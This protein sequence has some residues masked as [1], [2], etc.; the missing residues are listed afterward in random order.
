MFLLFHVKFLH[1]CAFS[2]HCLQK[3]SF[4][5]VII[6]Q[7]FNYIPCDYFT[8]KSFVGF[9]RSFSDVFFTFVILTLLSFSLLTFDENECNLTRLMIL[10]SFFSF[11]L[12]LFFA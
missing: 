11:A 9:V 4:P 5:Q 12:N 1:Y 7:Q 10:P 6:F 3:E 8:S 2:D